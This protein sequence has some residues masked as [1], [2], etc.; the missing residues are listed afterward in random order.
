MIFPCPGFATALFPLVAAE[1]VLLEAGTL[2]LRE[3]AG[4]GSSSE[5]DSQATSSL[6]TVTD[7]GLVN[8]GG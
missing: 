4:A 1:V 7:I 8:C 6:V 3:G 2:G 5:K